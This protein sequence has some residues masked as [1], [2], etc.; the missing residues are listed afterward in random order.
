VIAEQ[1]EGGRY[2]QK[3]SPVQSFRLDW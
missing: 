3:A 1:F 2:Y